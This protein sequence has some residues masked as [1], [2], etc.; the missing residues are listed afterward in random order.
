M[1]I[2]YKEP[3]KA[4]RTM[5]IPNELKVIQQ[6]VDGYIETIRVSDKTILVVNEEGRRKEMNPNFIL[7]ANG[8][9]EL[10]LGSA[11]FCGENGEEFASLPDDELDRIMDGLNKGDF[12]L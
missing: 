4:P 11:I 3:G 1:R 7:A 2:L 5:V 6:L 9:I 8:Y 12:V 10:I